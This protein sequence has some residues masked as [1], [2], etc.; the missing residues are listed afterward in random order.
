MTQKLGD[1]AE[2]LRD[3]NKKVQLI[4][5]FNGSGKTRLSREFKEL[6]DP[7]NAQ[8][9]DEKKTKIFYYN[10]FTED[11]FYW[12]NDLTGDTERKLKIHPNAYT[13]LALEEMG[14]DRE[15]IENFQRYTNVN[16]TPQFNSEY[17]IKGQDDKDVKVPAFSEVTFSIQRGDD[18]NVDNLKISK[19][20][21]SN[22]IWSIF[23]TLMDQIIS[24]LN[25]VEVND[26]ETDQFNDL[27]YIFID[28]PVSSLDDNHLIQLAVDI[29]ELVKKSDYVD[30]KGLR[31]IIT[32]HN[33]LFYNILH[34]EFSNDDKELGYKRNSFAKYRLEKDEDGLC[35]L[36]SQPNDSSFSYHLY[37]LNELKGAIETGDI[38]KYHFNFLRNILEKTSTFLGHKKWN[39]LLPK[40]DDGRP[41]PYQSRILN[42]ASHSKHSGQEIPLITD[43]D[44]RV[45]RYLVENIV[46]NY[47]NWQWKADNG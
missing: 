32:T 3:A 7:K 36:E 34:N 44:K 42:I 33:P 45:L 41:N 27:E 24:T 26:R 5:A 11:L 10:A 16:L 17:T 30:G 12:D 29:A 25:T 2:K 39:H 15:I 22:L 4:Y 13:K 28:D 40:M 1:I 6:I 46:E 47:Q 20:E 18:D 37:L 9:E 21:E 35:R 38:R 43:D 14:L 23:Y 8:V 19:G 31:F